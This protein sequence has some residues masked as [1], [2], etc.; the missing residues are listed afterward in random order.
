MKKHL[1]PLLIAAALAGC[2]KAEIVHTDKNGGVTRAGLWRLWANTSLTVDPATGA[3]HYTSEPQ[4][5]A[6]GKALDI[7]GA[8]LGR[9]PKPLV[10]EEPAPLFVP[11]SAPE[12][13]PGMRHVPFVMPRPIGTPLRRHLIAAKRGA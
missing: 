7:A 2:V 4:S 13:L 9:V 12:A 3:I 5:E 6:V 1:L 8:A 11:Q 10:T